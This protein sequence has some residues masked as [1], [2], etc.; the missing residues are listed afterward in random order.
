MRPVDAA[1]LKKT[2]P[3]DIFHT[4]LRLLFVNYKYLH[5]H[6]TLQFSIGLLRFRIYDFYS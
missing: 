1:H 3:A 5:S 4:F 6:M 2:D